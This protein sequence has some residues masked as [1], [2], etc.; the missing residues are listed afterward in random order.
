[1]NENAVHPGDRRSRRCERW[2]GI[3]L[4]PMEEARMFFEGKGPVPETLRRLAGRLHEA[5][6]PHIFIGATAVYAHGYE[7]TTRDVDV[8]MRPGDLERFRRE[9]VGREYDAVA[10]HSRRFRDQATG[11]LIDV[12]VAGEI[13][14]NARKQRE[15]RFPDPAEATD[16]DGLPLVTLARLIELKLV[17]WRLKDWA[18]VVELIR[19]NN[20]DERYG[21]Q[22]NPLV[23][24]AYLQCHDQKLEEDRYNPERDDPP[25]ADAAP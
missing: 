21:D 1:M 12:L 9:L 7:R 16:V 18:D 8:C 4:H 13:A 6:I 20:L 14:G 24:Q 5:G 2:R 19:S 25:P 22:Y 23:R 15:V 10:G 11:V 3:L 17:T